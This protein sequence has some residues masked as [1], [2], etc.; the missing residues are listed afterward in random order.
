MNIDREKALQAF[1]DYVKNYDMTDEKVKLKIDHTYRVC[2]LCQQ[3]ATQ[4]GFDED[5]IEIAWIWHL[6]GR[7]VHRPRGVWC[8][9]PL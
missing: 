5:E 9:Y 1:A 2:S 7:K 3:I 8:G 6:C 4:S